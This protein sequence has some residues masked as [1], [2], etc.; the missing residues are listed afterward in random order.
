MCGRRFFL[1]QGERIGGGVVVQIGLGHVRV[2]VNP[3]NGV[4]VG[5]TVTFLLGGCD[6]QAVLLPAQPC[7]SAIEEP[8]VGVSKTKRFDGGRL[9]VD[10]VDFNFLTHQLAQS[11]AE[12][13]RVFVDV[14]VFFFDLKCDFEAVIV[15]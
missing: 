11:V 2:D 14:L 15:V 1:H 9:T 3:R 13:L 7:C 8:D 5:S 10:R 6:L 12:F 4:V